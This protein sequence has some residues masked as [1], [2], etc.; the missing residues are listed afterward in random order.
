[1]SDEL[2]TPEIELA[3]PELAAWYLDAL[4]IFQLVASWRSPEVSIQELLSEDG[5]MGRR[6]QSWN[7]AYRREVR[8]RIP[9]E[10]V[11]PLDAEIAKLHR[12]F[13]AYRKHLEE[14]DNLS[15]EE[16]TDVRAPR[17]RTFLPFDIEVAI[18][19]LSRDAQLKAHVEGCLA[20]SREFLHRADLQQQ[21][22]AAVERSSGL[23]REQ[24][25]PTA[26]ITSPA[27][28]EAPDRSVSP[29][30]VEP[31]PPGEGD[32]EPT[33]LSRWQD[34][35]MRFV[36]GRTVSV[37]W[38]GMRRRLLTAEQLGLADARSPERLTRP[39]LAL[40]AFADMRGK[41][42]TGAKA[43]LL[44]GQGRMNRDDVRRLVKALKEYFH[45]PGEPIALSHD[46]IHWEASFT[47]APEGAAP[48][49]RT[50]D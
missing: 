45:A 33:R 1:M 4:E 37:E 15:P 2:T 14:I 43:P 35:V 7:S 44:E 49:H 22:R 17:K 8:P 16:L 48:V 50:K 3:T 38:P 30:T 31:P 10:I 13:L 25:E 21:D 26:S 28:P 11:Q 29:T 36:D 5:G 24:S 39:W 19:L 12:H 32:A 18:P 23:P 47:V 46:R 9:A 27:A 41:V 6:L 34:L 40:K 20:V 42:E